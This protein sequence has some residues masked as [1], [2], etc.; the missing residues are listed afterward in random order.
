MII[1]RK[2]KKCVKYVKTSII[3]TINAYAF[4]AFWISIRMDNLKTKLYILHNWHLHSHISLLNK[5]YWFKDLFAMQFLIFN[6]NFRLSLWHVLTFL[7]QMTFSKLSNIIFMHASLF[8][9][10]AKWHL[11]TWMTFTTY[12][13]DSVGFLC[14]FTCQTVCYAQLTRTQSYQFIE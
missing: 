6:E 10:S 1:E 7:P 14:D 9:R 13:D 4:I 2:V 11:T 12:L 8:Y 5:E 3:V